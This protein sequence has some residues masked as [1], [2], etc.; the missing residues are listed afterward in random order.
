M[1]IM[2]PYNVL[3]YDESMMKMMMSHDGIFKID[4]GPDFEGA[5]PGTG[6]EGRPVRG[7]LEAGH[8]EKILS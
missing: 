2:P 5:V 8:L 4:S 1:Y 7:A 6:G 3:Q